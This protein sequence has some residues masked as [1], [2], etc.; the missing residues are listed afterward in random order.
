MTKDL[1]LYNPGNIE[2]AMKFAKAM[3]QSGLL[4]TILKETS[5]HFSSCTM[6]I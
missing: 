2:E 4:Q 3:S 5:K 1:S 6:G